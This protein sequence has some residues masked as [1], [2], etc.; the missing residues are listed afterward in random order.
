MR[1]KYN[2]IDIFILL[3]VLFAISLMSYLALV[4]IR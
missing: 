2:G 4:V 1:K 3:F